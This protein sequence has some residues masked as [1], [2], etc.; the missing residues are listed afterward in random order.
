MTVSLDMLQALVHVADSASVSQAAQA[1]GV[2]K[3]VVSKRVAQL[4]QE[5]G[6]TLFAR[7]TRRVALTP[8]GEVY[9]AY[10]RRALAELQ[11]GEERLHA[12]RADLTG[13]I[14]IT[15][16]V[17]W[18]QRVLARILPTFLQR[19]PGVE[20]ALQLVD[21]RVDVAYER[22]DLALRWTPLAPPGLVSTPVTRVGWNLVAA[23]S[24]LDTHGTPQTPQDLVQQ[25]CLAYWSGAADD[26]WTLVQGD[27]AVSVRVC[28]R[29][30]ADNPEV[31]REAAL[32]GLGIALLPDFLCADD[33][34]QGHLQPVLADWTPQTRF[35]N[36][37][38]A[39]ATP[40]RMR[41]VRNQGLLAFLREQLGGA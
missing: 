37:I 12:L 28:S 19:H 21:R 20:V 7:S 18:G 23:P 9:L 15:A 32:A 38:S 10:A 41:L 33:L 14:R 5:V 39:M 35:G 8:A 11:A 6:A 24:L 26:N 29:F 22:I 2:G 13:T 16:S 17:S 3:S 25:D 40:E 1:L 31:V 34:A 27:Q 36:T 30:H 4:E